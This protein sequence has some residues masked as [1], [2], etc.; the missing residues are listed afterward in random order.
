MDRIAAAAVEGCCCGA[1][2]YIMVMYGYFIAQYFLYIIIMLI[3]GNAAGLQCAPDPG[4][5]LP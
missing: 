4:Q 5:C 3:A 1:G 2:V